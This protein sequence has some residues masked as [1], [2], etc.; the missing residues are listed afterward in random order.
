MTS[1]A[2]LLTKEIARYRPTLYRLALLQIRDKAA[3]DDAT[4][5]TLLAALEGIGRFRGEASVKTWLFAILRH[6]VVDVL[7][8]RG[9]FVPP[10]SEDLNAEL[11][12]TGFDTLFDA[13]DCWAAPKNVWA[14]PETVVERK[15][16]FKV[17]EACL[18]RLPARAR[19]APSSCAS[20]STLRRRKSPPSSMYRREICA[21]C[22]IARACS[23]GFVSILA[24]SR[25]TDKGK[26][27]CRDT[28]WL[29]SDAR[30]RPLTESER[31]S[32]ADHI[33]ECSLCQGASKQFG[34]LFREVG[35]YLK[36]EAPDTEA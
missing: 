2:L 19:H 13:E 31:A 35:A 28:T 9:R 23:S 27:T 16:F 7:R 24:G 11:D 26:V 15:A 22:F 10:P 17:L 18:T 33:A 32:L 3:A 6:K 20:G 34:A 21:C 14:N 29:V 1:A 25:M 5:E 4:Q 12:I 8:H 30:D 36:G